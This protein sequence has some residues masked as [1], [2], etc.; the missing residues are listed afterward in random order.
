V[1]ARRAALILVDADGTSER[2]LAEM[3]PIRFEV[4]GRQLGWH[5]DGTSLAV[6]DKPSPNR[7]FAIFLQALDGVRRELTLPPAGSV[8]DS[9]P[10]FSRDGGSLAFVRTSAVGVKDVYVMRPETG[11][12]RRVTADAAYVSGLSWSGDGS[13]LVFSSSRAGAPCLWTVPI[14][15]RKPRV[16][17]GLPGDAVYPSVSPSGR[18][19]AYMHLS[20]NT[21]IWRL[22]LGGRARPAALIQSTRLDAGPQFSPDGKS[23]ALTSNRHGSFEIW[24]C[25]ADGSNVVEL[26]SFRGPT[27]A[28]SPRWSPDG[29]YIVFDCRREGKTDIYVIPSRGGP[30]ARL[31]QGDAENAVPSWSRTGW[32]YFASNRGGDFQ[33]WKMRPEGGAAVRVTTGGGFAPAESPDGR[34]VYYSKGRTEA[35]VWRVPVDGGQEAPVLP[36]PPHGFWGYWT[37]AG[38]GIY[39]L[40]FRRDNLTLLNVVSTASVNFLEFA[41]GVIS[42]VAVIKDFRTTPYAGISVSPDRRW[43]LYTQLHRPVSNIMLVEDYP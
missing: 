18:R 15:A 12:A 21:Q 40:D 8:G 43:L 14:M 20:M 27:G 11:V 33:V 39:F 17:A 32:V 10:V 37:M 36:A 35:G 7:P 41:T 6:V 26:T 42:R 28:G 5:P 4:L 24:T 29:S 23:I 19:L 16:V 30:P 2:E 34:Y 38:D 31:T 22:S 9:D 13:R 25:R 3:Y 1:S